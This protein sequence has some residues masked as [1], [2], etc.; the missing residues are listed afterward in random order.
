M[1]EAYP[2][3]FEDPVET[4][5]K[6]DREARRYEAI[7]SQARVIRDKTARQMMSGRDDD[8]NR[9]PAVTN[10]E[11]ARLTGLTTARVSQ[12]RKGTR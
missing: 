5:R 3:L 9:V 7:K 11:V 1:I 10:A 8:G 2:E 4:M 6:A 12:L